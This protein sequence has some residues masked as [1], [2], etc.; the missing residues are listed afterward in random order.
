MGMGETAGM[1]DE[2]ESRGDGPDYERFEVFTDTDDHE[3]VECWTDGETIKLGCDVENDRCVEFS[4]E[5][6][7]EHRQELNQFSVATRP[8][9]GHHRYLAVDDGTFE[10][11]I[12]RGRTYRKDS[13][14]LSLH[15]DLMA[16]SSAKGTAYEVRTEK[17][18]YRDI[19]ESYADQLKP[20]T[21]EIADIGDVQAGDVPIS[22]TTDLRGVND[23][24]L[25][26]LKNDEYVKYV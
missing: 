1:T 2:N 14:V 6:F 3:H 22:V 8:S 12:H 26:R 9:V 11:S 17:L 23:S 21:A 25:E 18:G 13:H 20:T 15:D 4:Y 19:A 24:F 10:I 16:L 7:D 5:E